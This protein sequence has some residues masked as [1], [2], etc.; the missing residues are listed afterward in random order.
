[1][2]REGD[3]SGVREGGGQ[4]SN[5]R[6]GSRPGGDGMMIEHTTSIHMAT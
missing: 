2:Q 1:M 6:V 3:I 5:K 4:S